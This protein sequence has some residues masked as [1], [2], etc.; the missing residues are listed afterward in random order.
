MGSDKVNKGEDGSSKKCN[1]VD[2]GSLDKDVQ[3]KIVTSLKKVN[4]GNE[5]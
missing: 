1:D 2:W 3:V 5:G 4:E